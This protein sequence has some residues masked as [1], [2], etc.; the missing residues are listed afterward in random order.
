VSDLP[1]LITAG[2][3]D[4]RAW[5]R[6]ARAVLADIH[7]GKLQ[8]GDRLPAITTMAAQFG[9]SPGTVS[10]AGRELTDGGILTRNPAGPLRAPP[11]AP[12]R[13]SPHDAGPGN[14]GHDRPARLR[15]PPAD[16]R[17]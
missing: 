1:V 10:R 6:I 7:A 15:C 14:A 5:V 16:D 13:T 4:P 17:R 2:P 8:P 9:V 11:D 3:D 12:R